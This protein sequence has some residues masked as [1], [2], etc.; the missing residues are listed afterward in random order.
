G[1]GG[2][3]TTSPGTT[4]KARGVAL[5]PDGKIVAAGYAA[6]A[7]GTALFALARYNPDGTLDTSF[8]TSGIQTTPIGTST[9][10]SAV[11]LQPD[12]KIV[13]AG[14]ADVDGTRQ[15]ALARYGVTAA[16]T[17]STTPSTV[18]TTPPTDPA[19]QGQG[20][21]VTRSPQATGTLPRTGASAGPALAG[22]AMTVIGVVLRRTRPARRK[23]S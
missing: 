12:G 18:S 23:R 19:V 14:A 6:R 4:T 10:A 16:P 9:D 2:T 5:Q 7:D 22:L 1:T 17:V 11:V 20:T 13:A 21:N 3:Q 15:F 8:G